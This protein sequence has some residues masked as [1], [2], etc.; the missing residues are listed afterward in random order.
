MSRA[1]SLGTA[2]GLALFVISLA[3]WMW[4]GEWRWAVTGTVLVLLGAIVDVVRG[5]T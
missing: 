5:R 1:K 3:A 2:V 4:T